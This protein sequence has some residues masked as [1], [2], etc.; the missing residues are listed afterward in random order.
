MTMTRWEFF[1]KRI[2]T[3][4]TLKFKAYLINEENIKAPSLQSFK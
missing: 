4:M 3:E 1:M 2:T